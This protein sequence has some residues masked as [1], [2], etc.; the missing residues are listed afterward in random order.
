MFFQ[1][2]SAKT[3]VFAETRQGFKSFYRKTKTLLLIVYNT[4]SYKLA[5]K[6]LELRSISRNVVDKSFRFGGELPKAI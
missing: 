6:G 3:Y 5:C 1:T 4:R 2:R